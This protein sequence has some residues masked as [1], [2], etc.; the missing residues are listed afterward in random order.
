ML[1]KL[2]IKLGNKILFNSLSE[3]K[4]TVAAKELYNHYHIGSDDLT[5]NRFTYTVE[6]RALLEVLLEREGVLGITEFKGTRTKKS[7]IV[8]EKRADSPIIENSILF[9]NICGKPRVNDIQINIPLS[10]HLRIN[11]RD[12]SSIDA[13]NLLIVENLETFNLFTHSMC[14]ELSGDVLAIFRG[15]PNDDKVDGEVAKK[16]VNKDP[17][18][19]PEVFAQSIKDNKGIPLISYFD[20]DLAGLALMTHIRYDYCILPSRLEDLKKIKPNKDDFLNQRDKYM[21]S[22]TRV[23]SFKW[24]PTYIDYILDVRKGSFVQERLSAFDVP[25]SLFKL[26]STTHE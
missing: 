17:Y 4:G 5:R 23:R 19:H 24:L 11:M 6:D 25:L 14:S 2:Q 15:G 16:N 10:G 8:H 7:S 12:I 13:T 20:F 18:I 21:P 26:I 3:H 9:R 22:D 1:S